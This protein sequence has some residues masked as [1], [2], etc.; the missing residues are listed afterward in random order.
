MPRKPQK[1][2]QLRSR[3]LYQPIAYGLHCL[4]SRDDA[5]G[6]VYWPLRVR[7]FSRQVCRA[8]LPPDSYVSL[9]PLLGLVPQS[10]A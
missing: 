1:I 7:L 2:R 9:L 10:I 4:Q 8:Q 3:I 5:R 6:P